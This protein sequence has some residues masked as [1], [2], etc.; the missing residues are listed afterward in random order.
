[1]LFIAV[2]VATAASAA[3]EGRREIVFAADGAARM[4]LRI[5]PQQAGA[6]RLTLRS[7]GDGTERSETLSAADVSVLRTLVVKPGRYTLRVH[8]ARHRPAERILHITGDT[9]IGSIALQRAPSLSGIV[10]AGGKPLANARVEWIGGSTTTGKDGRFA[11][12]FEDA[13][14]PTSIAVRASGRGTKFVDVPA[15][16]A[17]VTL[18]DVELTRGGTVRVE[19]EGKGVEEVLIGARVV[20]A[21]PRWFDRKRLVKGATKATFSDLERGAYIVLVRG[22]QPLAQLTQEVIL[23][24]GD[25]RVVP[26]A[27]SFAFVEGRITHGGAPLANSELRLFARNQRWSATLQTDGKGELTSPIWEQGLFDYEIRTPANKAPIYGSVKLSGGPVIP[28]TIDAPAGSVTGR[29]VDT[30]GAP[31]AGASVGLAS[32]RD[33]ATVTLRTKTDEYGAF[34][35]NGVPAGAQTIKVNVASYLR[36]EPLELE[37]QEGEQRDVQLVASRGYPRALHVTHASGAPAVAALVVAEGRVRAVA[38][39]DAEGHVL[40]PTPEDEGVVVYVKPREGSLLVRRLPSP[41]AEENRTTK[42]VVPE[43]SASLRIATKTTEG[44]ALPNVGLLMRVNGETVTP[45]LSEL[46]LFTGENG[47]AHLQHIPPGVYE[48]WPYSTPA[49]AARLFAGA[50]YGAAPIVVNVVTGANDAVI[51]FQKKR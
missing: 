41:L 15:T 34:A 20:D 42:L 39:T 4:S 8:V 2:L 11:Q 7:L 31:V 30:S 33:T 28:M 18:P 44:A 45:E 35:F 50:P 47:D 51:R 32:K 17:D 46:A 6:G 13:A 43:G 19:I 36:P 5:E 38:S 10:R 9:A 40:L 12:T 37:L 27:L 24:T 3:D 16:E 1:M 49:E 25:T 14:W 23:G 29:V 26:V 21:P 48:F 22:S